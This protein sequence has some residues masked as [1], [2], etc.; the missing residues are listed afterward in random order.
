MNKF[1]SQTSVFIA[2][3]FSLL[4]FTSCSNSVGSDDDEHEHEDPT[5]LELIHDGDVVIQYVNG[6][7]SELEHLHYHVGEEY[8]FEVEFLDDHGDHV[9][10]E[11]LEDGYNLDWVIGDENI[12][13]IE[14]HTEDGRWSFH[15]VPLA[16]G[17]TKVQFM[18]AHG[19]HSH[20]STPTVDQENAI[21]FHV[22]EGDHE[23]GDHDH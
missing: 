2:I 16:E 14:Q 22:E 11:D 19:D 3:T 15:L 9:H 21:E 20:L 10:A 18:L 7:V 13:E 12:L 4:I 23:D 8:H 1:I 5:G 17:G 6:E